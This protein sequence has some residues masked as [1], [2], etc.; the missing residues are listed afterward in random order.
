MTDVVGEE[1]VRAAYRRGQRKIVVDSQA[2]ITPQAFD[3]A[4]RLSMRLVRAEP[5]AAPPLS[6]S[7]GRALNRTLYRRHPGFV[8]TARHT[9]VR[10]NPLSKVA[11]LGAGGQGSALAGLL[12]STSAAERVSI[13][14]L[15][16]GLAESVAIDIQHASSLMSTNVRVTG[17]GT[18]A[19]LDG[20]HVVVVTPEAA[21]LPGR[22]GL[23]IGETAIAAEAIA[24]HAPDAVIVFGGWPSEV[25]T[26]RLRSI[27]NFAP[28]R[29]LGT[30]ATLATSRLIN[31]IAA[32]LNVQQAE[33]D[34]IAMG[35]DGRYFPVLSASR[36]RGRPLSSLLGP[37]ELDA[38]M[39]LAA[40]AAQHVQSL[41]ASRPPSVAPAH[42]ALGVISAIRGA[43]PGPIPVSI[44]L[45]GAYGIDSGVIGITAHL[46]AQGVRAPVELPL[47]DNELKE[48]RDAAETFQGELTAL[49]ELPD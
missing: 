37:T 27:G 6:T 11:I 9:N 12:A 15:I 34:A 24:T 23:L 22:T 28:E 20:A 44:A 2:I 39:A 40:N 8:P 48:L 1:V 41:R 30:G 3:A 31:A 35:I 21:G 7:P 42:A 32:F 38:V 16:P 36:V 10:A 29:V 4:D 17:S 45:D 19:Q 18:I 26:E 13:I 43:R 47:S 46:S 33:I 25:F 14:D 5:T 49:A